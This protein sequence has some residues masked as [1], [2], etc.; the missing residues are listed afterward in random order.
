M[1]SW[2]ARPCHTELSQ[3]NLQR[4]FFHVTRKALNNN[5]TSQ[6]P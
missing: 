1:V 3:T 2:I 5:P 4:A 6:V